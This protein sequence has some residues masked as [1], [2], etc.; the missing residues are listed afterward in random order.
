LN[1]APIID[2]DP[3]VVPDPMPDPDPSV[4]PL[5]GKLHTMIK[6]KQT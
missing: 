4:D 2:P 6:A 5:A 3:P 1:I